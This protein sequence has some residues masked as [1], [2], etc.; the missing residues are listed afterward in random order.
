[1]SKVT[2]HVAMPFVPSVRGRLREGDAQQATSPSHARRM[3]EAMAKRAG[4]RG[5]A[6]AF[7]RSGDPDLGEWADAVVLATYGEVPLQLIDATASGP[8]DW[9]DAMPA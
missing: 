4:P 9:P 3:A 2:Y 6:V 8:R 1:M 5:G 7:S